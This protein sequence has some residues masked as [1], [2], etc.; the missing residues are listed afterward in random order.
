MSLNPQLSV[1]IIGRNEALNL[2][3]LHVSLGPLFELLDSVQTIYVDSASSDESVDIGKELFDEVYVLAESP[4]LS[5]SAGRNIGTVN[6]KAD[7]IL[8]LDGDMEFS[9]TFAPLILSAIDENP[10]EKGFTGINVYHYENGLVSEKWKTNKGD[11]SIAFH[12]GGAVMLPR[13]AVIRAGNWSFG[14]Y[15][16]EEIDIYC[17]LRAIGVQVIFR[18][19]VMI[20]H[21]THWEGWL[22]KL[23]RMFI[24][25]ISIFNRTKNSRRLNYYLGFGQSLR[26]NLSNGSFINY[27]RFF[28]YPFV[29]LGGVI[30]AA[31]CWWLLSWEIGALFFVAILSWISWKKGPLYCIICAAFIPRGILGFFMYPKNF[32]PEIL[33]VYKNRK[34]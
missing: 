34:T 30:L 23:W 2:K 29:F 17:R 19:C 5:A 8:Y 31:I 14:I 16:N 28:P 26:S 11:N 25:P 32:S 24:P 7:W 1:C 13:D 20:H 33:A 10:R 9:A 22:L 6:A 21:Y 4:H 3:R 27:V 18:E 15:S 12:F